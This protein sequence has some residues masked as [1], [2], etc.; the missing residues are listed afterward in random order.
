MSRPLGN[1][2]NPVKR[3]AQNQQGVRNEEQK[4]VLGG[5]QIFVGD[6]I[7]PGDPGNDPTYTSA[8]SPPY[9]NG[10]TYV[11]GYPIWF[12]HGVDGETDMGGMYDVVTG[13]YVSGDLGFRMPLEW[14]NEAPP[15]HAFPLKLDA[16]L[17]TMAVQEITITV[18]TGEVRIWFP[19]CADLCVT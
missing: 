11:A 12:A 5:P 8:S 7:A 14:A 2:D 19:I 3:I 17:Y 4:P 10:L 15:V 6:F 13:G 1:R 18:T 9:L 16:G